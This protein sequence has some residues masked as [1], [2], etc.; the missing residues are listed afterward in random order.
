MINSAAIGRDA[1]TV[2]E[3][4]KKAPGN[5]KA[6]RRFPEGK[7]AV[8]LGGDPYCVAE[9]PSHAYKDKPAALSE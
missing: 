9:S 2:F 4:Q 8:F 1:V 7:E 6:T 3:A 5:Q